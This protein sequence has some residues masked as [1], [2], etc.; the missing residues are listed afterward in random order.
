[1]LE[2]GPRA[3]DLRNRVA[4]YRER[5]KNERNPAKASRYLKIAEILAAEA[6]ALEREPAQGR[7][8]DERSGERRPRDAS[9]I[10]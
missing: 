8:V 10:S 6:A 4:E 1:M 2:I 3:A 7:R 5:A 9:A